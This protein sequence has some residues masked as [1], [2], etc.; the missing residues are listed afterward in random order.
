MLWLYENREV[1][2]LFNC[3]TGKA[4]AFK[5]L[6]EAVFAALDKEP[7]IDYIPTPENIRDKYQYFTEA[8]MARLQAAGYNGGSTSL[9]E[10]VKRY[11]QDYLAAEDSYI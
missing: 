1:S 4:R 6:A 9:E 5:D 8:K 2:G 10:G 7:D 11:V 3:G